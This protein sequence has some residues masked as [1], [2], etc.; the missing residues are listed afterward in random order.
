MTLTGCVGVYGCIFRL[1]HWLYHAVPPSRRAAAVSIAGTFVGGATV[2]VGLVLASHFERGEAP[3]VS[4]IL[5]TWAA[6]VGPVWEQRLVQGA[7]DR[8][9]AV[10]FGF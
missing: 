10:L 6:A 7:C 5:G 8:V 4:E 9:G 1:L 3:V 2:R